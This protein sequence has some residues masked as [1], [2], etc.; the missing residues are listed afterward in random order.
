MI[1]RTWATPL[2][3]GA[4]LVSA[5][6]GAALFFEVDT[7]TGK[8]A[9]QWLGWLLVLAIALHVST[10]WGSFRAHLAGTRGRLIAGAFL[11][12][13]LGAVIP[14]PEAAEDAEDEAGGEQSGGDGAERPD[15]WPAAEYGLTHAPLRAVAAVAGRDV[16]AVL[17][18]LRSAGFEDAAAER[19][20][21]ELVGDDRGRAGAVL[22]AVFSYD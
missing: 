9:H 19:S 12:F 18:S 8:A 2:A 17:A 20:I 5:L 3:L 21:D 22:A 6:T 4:F 11:L 15:G 7:S 16:D 1:S 10:S 13:A 14:L